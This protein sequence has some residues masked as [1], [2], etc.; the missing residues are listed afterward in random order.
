MHTTLSV[1]PRYCG[2][3]LIGFGID[4]T[5]VHLLIG[6]GME[7]AWAR[8]ISLLVAM[9]AT[10]TLN[11]FLVFRQCQPKPLLNQWF[12]YMLC[13]GFGNFCNYWIFVTMVSLHWQVVSAPITAVAVGSI[14]AWL[15]NFAATR[16]IVF[17][18]LKSLPKSSLQ[19]DPSPTGP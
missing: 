13:N 2:V 8:V 18:H 16:W 15:I 5:I 4:A 3:S 11:R 7:P 17:P 12:S 9:H 6:Q 10:F 1:I 19:S 14:C